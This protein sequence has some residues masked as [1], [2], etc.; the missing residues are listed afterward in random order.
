M[1]LFK[2]AD[3][4]APKYLGKKDVLVEGSKIKKL[5]IILKSV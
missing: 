2:N 4:Y 5:L 3:V 1:I